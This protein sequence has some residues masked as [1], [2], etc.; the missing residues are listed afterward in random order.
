MLWNA[1]EL[2]RYAVRASDGRLGVVSDLLFEDI[3]WMVRWAV[4]DTA[5]WFSSRKVLLPVSAL[6]QPDSKLRHCPVDLTMQQVERSPDI[7]TDRPVSRQT[8]IHIYDYYDLD[9]YWSGGYAPGRETAFA[10][11]LMLSGSKRT[12]RADI[13]PKK[14]DRH[15]RSTNAVTGYDIQ[16]TDCEIGRVHDFLVDDADWSIAY[17]VVLTGTWWSGTKV[18]IPSNSV[19]E[20]DWAQRLMY[21]N[22]DCQKV[23]NSPVYHYPLSSMKR[24][25]KDTGQPAPRIRPG[26]GWDDDDRSTST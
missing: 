4:V 20:I 19:R 23:K 18:L 9:P 26:E 5:R 10:A 15:L 3:G 1:A 21:L 6:A 14:G 16:A 25:R 7:D 2:K 13:Q 8:E 24:E 17:I 12:V 22:I 11:R